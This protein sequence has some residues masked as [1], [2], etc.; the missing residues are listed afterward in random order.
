MQYLLMWLEGP[1]QSWGDSSKYGPRDTLPFPTKSGIYGMILAAMGAKGT[2][3]NLLEKLA[4]CSQSI[5]AFSKTSILRDFHIVGSGYDDQDGW[6]RLSIPKKQDGSAAVGGGSKMTYRYYLQEA[7]FGV[8]QA[9]P[10]ELVDQIVQALQFPVYS[11]CLGRKSCVPSEYVYQG[12]F[13]SEKE[14]IIT[15]Q[16]LG[17]QK[18]LK[19]LLMVSENQI[20]DGDPQIIADVPVRFGS[21]KEYR[22]RTVYVTNYE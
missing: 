22:E 12:I 14:A 4:V 19:Q 5:I 15:A 1:F 20:V 6:Q 7:K 16:T 9:L 3:E 11:P 21:Q 13:K 17:T 10:A 8:I 2:Q 18:G